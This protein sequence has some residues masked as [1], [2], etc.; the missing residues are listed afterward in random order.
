MRTLDLKN[1]R[2]AHV[3]ELFSVPLD[4]VD[5]PTLSPEED[6]DGSTEG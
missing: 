6:Q 4:E 3:P 2:C 5:S 1:V